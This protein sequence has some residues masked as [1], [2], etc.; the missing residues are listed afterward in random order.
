MAYKAPDYTKQEL[1]G[2]GMEFLAPNILIVAIAI[3]AI[4]GAPCA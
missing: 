1:D 4:A 2:E 3:I